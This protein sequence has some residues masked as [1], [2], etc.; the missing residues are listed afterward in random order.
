MGGSMW[1]SSLDGEQTVTVNN[2]LNKLSNQIRSDSINNAAFEKYIKDSFRLERKGNT[3]ILINKKPTEISETESDTPLSVN[4]IG[5]QDAVS[6][7]RKIDGPGSELAY[8]GMVELKEY[9]KSRNP[10]EKAIAEKYYQKVSMSYFDYLNNGRPGI[11]YEEFKPIEIKNNRLPPSE[12]QR[13]NLKTLI[14]IINNKKNVLLFD[15]AHAIW[16][17]NYCTSTKFKPFQIEEVNNW[18]NLLK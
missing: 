14:D 12:V 8:E 1:K 16:W 17:L 7:M 10:I 4:E 9:I 5:I 3:A 11:S 2:N 18:Y 6:K 13:K 15:I